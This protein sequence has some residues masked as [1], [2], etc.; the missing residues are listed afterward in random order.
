MKWLATLLFLSMHL[1]ANVMVLT[2]HFEKSSALDY[3]EYLVTVDK[4]LESLDISAFQPLTKANLGYLNNKVVWTKL[5]L[6]NNSENVQRIVALNPRAG[7]DTVKMY[8]LDEDKIIAHAHMGDLAP[9]NNRPI[10]SLHSAINFTINP[11]STLTLYTMY[12]NSVVYYVE[13]LLYSSGE[14]FLAEVC[15]LGTSFMLLTLAI[16]LIIY[17]IFIATLLPSKIFFVFVLHLI[18]ICLCYFSINGIFYFLTQGNYNEFREFMT[19]SGIVLAILLLSYFE[20]HFFNLKSIAP[21]LYRFGIIM[22]VI[23]IIPMFAVT[24][25]EWF[26]FEEILTSVVHLFVFMLYCT[27]EIILVYLVM[28]KIPYAVHYF[29]AHTFYT[30]GYMVYLEMLIGVLPQNFFTLHA[31]LFG[32]VCEALI[33]S[34]TMYLIVQKSLKEKQKAEELLVGHS[35]FFSVGRQLAAIVHQWKVPLYRMSTIALYFESLLIKKSITPKQLSLGVTQMNQTIAFMDETITSFHNFYRREYGVKEFVIF[36]KIEKIV[37]MLRPLL[38]SHS[39]TVI[40][41]CNPNLG[42][43]SKPHIFG[44][45]VLILVQNAIDV[46]STSPQEE[47]TITLSSFESQ[48]HI[49]IRV[50]DNGGGIEHETLKY[51]FSETTQSKNGLGFGLHLA[52]FLVS[53]ELGGDITAYNAPH[54]ACFELRISKSLPN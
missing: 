11:Y 45:V 29:I 3:T 25:R 54:G 6:Y 26:P 30:T 49:G 41:Q 37:D 23:S 15:L 17:N 16:V 53:K 51:L 34:F 32:M 19:H 43:C 50:E 42:I 31:G 40:N 52:Y 1:C 8:L 33:V 21:K 22:M 4:N 24:Y 27:V 46:L 18:I 12:E 38:E 2:E 13:T 39:I 5:K 44:H 14:F 7:M 28:K 10:K 47:R 20:L 36:E 48:S 35:Q 9:F